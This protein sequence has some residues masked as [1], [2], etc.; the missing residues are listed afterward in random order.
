ML[1]AVLVF[2]LIELFYIAA[3][4]SI[5][6]VALAI[7]YTIYMILN[8]MCKY[9]KVTLLVIGSLWLLGVMQSLL[10]I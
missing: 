7:M 9:W 10:S 4:L 2:A 1:V 5:V 8:I 6:F 3:I